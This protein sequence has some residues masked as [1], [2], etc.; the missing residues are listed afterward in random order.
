MSEE[1]E[2]AKTVLTSLISGWGVKESWAKVL[3]GAIVGALAA[4][5]YNLF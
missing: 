5:G 4:L 1:Q 3:A 2:K